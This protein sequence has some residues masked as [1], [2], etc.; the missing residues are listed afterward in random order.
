MKKVQEIDLEFTFSGAKSV[1]HF[2]D[3]KY[4]GSST[5]Q[6]VDFIVEYDS[7]DIFIEVKDPDNP[8]A[9]NVAAFEEKMRSGKL[10]QSL[11]G[12]FRDTLFF[13][14]IQGK[15]DSGVLYIV[16]IS[17]QRL[18][19][20]LLVAKQDELR[21]SIPLRHAD[22]SRDCAASCIVLNEEQWKR[23][24]GGES[25]RRISAGAAA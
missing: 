3:D 18:E 16:L 11:A 1:V 23:Q 24:F 21:R 22:W 25:L 12:K 19:N 5:V 9:R 8:A 20:A 4:H 2:D 15:A 14:H 13:R 17:M 7:R 6:R 10:V